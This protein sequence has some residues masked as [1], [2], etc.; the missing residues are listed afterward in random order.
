MMFTAIIKTDNAAY[1][2]GGGITTDGRYSLSLNL[3][4]I[5]NDILEQDE[6]AIVDYNGN[7]VGQWI[8][9]NT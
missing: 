5:A 6:G 4:R 3:K 1:S 2:D 8:L 9:N 7:V